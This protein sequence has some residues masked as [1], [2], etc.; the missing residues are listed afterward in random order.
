MYRFIVKVSQSPQSLQSSAPTFK[1]SQSNQVM[2]LMQLI[3]LHYIC[4]LSTLSP[5][6]VYRS[7]TWTEPDL[8]LLTCVFPYLR[9]SSFSTAPRIP[10]RDQLQSL[11]AIAIWILSPCAS[12]TSH[13]HLVTPQSISIN[14][15]VLPLTSVSPSLYRDNCFIKMRIV[16]NIPYII[17]AW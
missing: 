11:Q 16:C 8:G 6:P 4:T 5:R 14:T 3:K 7:H 2:Q 15:L 9:R 1:R 10:A 12:L 17:R 13:H